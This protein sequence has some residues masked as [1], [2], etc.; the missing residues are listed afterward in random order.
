MSPV[1]YELG[2]ISQKTTFFIVTPSPTN[3]G[4]TCSQFRSV[5]CCYIAPVE[6]KP[7]DL[8][9]SAVGSCCAVMALRCMW[10]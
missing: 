5:L 9:Q 2:F 10:P 8:Y 1:G 4:F 7:A 3:L 6:R